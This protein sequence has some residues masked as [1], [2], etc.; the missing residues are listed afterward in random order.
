MQ[1]DSYAIRRLLSGVRGGSS[2]ADERE[3]ESGVGRQ[4]ER[5]SRMNL[6]EMYRAKHKEWKEATLKVEGEVPRQLLVS[7]K[8]VS[9]R[10]DEEG[11]LWISHE[12]R[13]DVV[14]IGKEDVLPLAYW[15]D[16]LLQ[17]RQ[18][19]PATLAEKREAK[20]NKARTFLD[21]RA[22]FADGYG[23][24]CDELRNLVEKALDRL[25]DAEEKRYHWTNPTGE[26]SFDR[27]V[28][29]TEAQVEEFVSLAI[30]YTQSS[31]GGGVNLEELE[32]MAL[33]AVCRV[34]DLLIAQPFKSQ[35]ESA[36]LRDAKIFQKCGLS[37]GEE[38]ALIAD[39]NSRQ[40]KKSEVVRE[41]E[42]KSIAMETSKAAIVHLRARSSEFFITDLP[43]MLADVIEGAII[44]GRQL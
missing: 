7:L 29:L 12:I 44:E 27:P 28:P 11:D 15:L 37:T 25:Q 5:G 16:T 23:L 21:L 36:Q 41:K 13:G 39:D 31:R 1:A 9:A 24:S 14:V 40:G 32:R 6:I 33:L 34:T 10:I 35:N 42:I 4:I 38:D 8:T 19:K 17:E 3:N 22:A 43:K 20:R 2:S 30:M 26:D 18:P